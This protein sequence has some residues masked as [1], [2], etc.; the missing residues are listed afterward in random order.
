MKTK[1]LIE[2]TKNLISISSRKLNKMTTRFYK[3]NNHKYFSDSC[4]SNNKDL[5]KNI[6]VSLNKNTS[7]ERVVFFD[8]QSTTPLDPRVLDAMLPYMTVRFGNPHSNSHEY[9]WEAEKAVEK[10]REVR[11]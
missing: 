2:K 11:G 10:A 9:G 4:I 7:G 5:G 3:S 8:L 1:I 6:N